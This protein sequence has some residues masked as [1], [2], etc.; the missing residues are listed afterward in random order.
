MPRTLGGRT[1]AVARDTTFLTGGV[2][3]IGLGVALAVGLAWAGAGWPY[4]QA[5]LGVLVAIGLG[6]FFVSVGRAER[7]ERRRFPA[8]HEAGRTPEPPGPP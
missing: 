7:H 8:E 6:G 4:V 5:W 1:D 2:L 3:V